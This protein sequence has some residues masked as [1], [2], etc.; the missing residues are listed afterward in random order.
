ML[1]NENNIIT[2]D[3]DCAG[4]LRNII[5]WSEFP[6]CVDNGDNTWV[7]LNYIRIYHLYALI[8]AL[9]II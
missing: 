2:V 7:N 6:A 4:I 8:I 3:D 5:C 9:L 1:L